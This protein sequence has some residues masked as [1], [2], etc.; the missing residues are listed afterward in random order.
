MLGTRGGAFLCRGSDK[1]FHIFLS[2]GRTSSGIIGPSAI[3]PLGSRNIFVNIC[4]EFFNFV[5]TK[6]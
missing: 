6:V 5:S 4:T 1:G 3:H 2:K